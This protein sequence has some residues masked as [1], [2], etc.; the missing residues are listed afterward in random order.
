[1]CCWTPS[2]QDFNL[3]SMRV[4][5]GRS[6]VHPMSSIETPWASQRFELKVGCTPYLSWKCAGAMRQRQILHLRCRT[7]AGN[8][9][10]DQLHQWWG[11]MPPA[12]Q[13]GWNES[14]ET[15]TA[16]QHPPPSTHHPRPT[17]MTIHLD[18]P[19]PGHPRPAPTSTDQPAPAHH[20][21]PPTTHYHHRPPAATRCHHHLQPPLPTTAGHHGHHGH[22]A[23][24]LRLKKQ[25][26]PPEPPRDP[27]V[28]S[29]LALKWIVKAEHWIRW[30]NTCTE[31]AQ[32][33]AKFKFVDFMRCHQM[34]ITCIY[35]H[36]IYI[37]IWNLLFA[38]V[39][40]SVSHLV[41]RRD[42]KVSRNLQIVL[43]GVFFS[44]FPQVQVL[45]K[46]LFAFC[47]WTL[48]F[49]ILSIVIYLISY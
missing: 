25:Q 22:R 45:S 17:T 29:L 24:K 21:P 18:T 33:R 3:H 8:L 13:M 16:R 10:F 47:F 32:H 31:W 46:P 35:H 12:T 5:W 37:Y 14:K 41:R 9:F 36:H 20:R 23:R 40:V 42:N 4:C 7:T 15:H 2:L 44:F 11:S 49:F 34:Y 1:M 26:R 19:R 6:L 39:L 38:V 48:Q 30:S 27:G 28:F 43:F